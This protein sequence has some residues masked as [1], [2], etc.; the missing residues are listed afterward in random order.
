MPVLPRLFLPFAILLFS[1]LL[2]LFPRPTYAEP[3]GPPAPAPCANILRTD[4]LTKVSLPPIAITLKYKAPEFQPDGSRTPAPPFKK[5]VQVKVDFSKIGA[6]FAPQSSDYWESKF[7]QKSHREADLL[8][9]AD[10]PQ[11]FNKYNGPGQKAA[12]QVVVDDL[13]AKYV[14]YVWENPGLIDAG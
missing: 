1:I 10:D 11:E 9:L 12:P 4:E 3:G 8:E 7:P 2:T 13:R 5:A 14:K 6:I